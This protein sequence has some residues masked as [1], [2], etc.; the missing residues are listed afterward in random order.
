M[1][2]IKKWGD[3]RQNSRPFRNW[4]ISIESPGRQEKVVP[5]LLQLTELSALFQ[6]V[7]AGSSLIGS[8]M[9]TIRPSR[10]G[11]LA[12]RS[13]PPCCRTAWWAI[14]KPSP[15]PPLFRSLASATR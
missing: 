13:V 11:A 6:P 1:V 8:R 2:L 9:S 3:S 7:A 5:W 12:K 10:S 4:L 14:A 15:A